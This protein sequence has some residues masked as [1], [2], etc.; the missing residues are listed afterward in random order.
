M[1]ST[2]SP[3][4]ETSA[5]GAAAAEPS[6][7]VAQPIRKDEPDTRRSAGVVGLAVVASRV[8]G[9][10]RE[11]VFPAMF[12]GGKVL[13]AYYAAFQIP[14]LLRDL[15]AEG[16]LSIAFTTMFTTAW[17]TEGEKPAWELANLILSAMIFLIGALDQPYR[18]EVSVSPAPYQLFLDSV[19]Q[20]R[21]DTPK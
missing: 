13:D 17:D 21:R 9:L 12:G 20:T 10:G 19:S 8:F 14:N 4:P 16:A 3:A 15:F 18:G 5:E 7:A 2:E 11:L 6:P 1:T